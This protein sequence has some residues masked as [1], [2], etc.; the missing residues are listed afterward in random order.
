MRTIHEWRTL[1]AARKPH[2][3]FSERE[4][5]GIAAA[6]RNAESR[7]SGEIRVHVERR[8]PADP[9]LRAKELF[10]ALGMHRTARRNGVLIYLAVRDRRFAVV[11]DEGFHRAVPE[12]FWEEVASE[13]ERHFKAGRFLE[14]IH[15]LI[16]RISAEL[17]RHFPRTPDDLNELPDTPSP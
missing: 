11:G 9:L 7:T 15:G 2:R 12:R 14:G 13:M 1:R 6:I 5:H 8:C 3:F 10:S 4:R 16:D 17:G